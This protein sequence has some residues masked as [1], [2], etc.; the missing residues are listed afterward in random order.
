GHLRVPVALERLPL[1]AGGAAVAGELR[2]HRG[3]ERPAG[4]ERLLGD[5][6]GLG[7]GHVHPGAAGVHLPPALLRARRDDERDQVTAS[8]GPAHDGFLGT[9]L[10]RDVL[11]W[12]S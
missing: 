6:D 8:E 10:E 12:W 7:R 9:H 2:A 5:P 3:P 1:A 11:A 4:A